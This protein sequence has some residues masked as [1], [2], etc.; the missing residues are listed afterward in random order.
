MFQF[1]VKYKTRIV[2]PGFFDQNNPGNE[3]MD[4]P[5]A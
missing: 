5:A 2:V 1:F 4:T 3:R